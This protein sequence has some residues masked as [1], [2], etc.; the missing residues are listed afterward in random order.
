MVGVNIEDNVKGE[1]K[2][3]KDFLSTLLD[4]KVLEILR[5][6]HRKSPFYEDKPYSSPRVIF[7]LPVDIFDFVREKGKR[8]LTLVAFVHLHTND[9]YIPHPEMELCHAYGTNPDLY[10]DFK[11]ALV[12]G[13]I[14]KFA[15]V[16][17]TEKEEGDDDVSY[18]VYQPL[19]VSVS[20]EED[21]AEVEDLLNQMGDKEIIEQ[22]NVCIDPT[23][24][25]V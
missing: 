1:T 19:Y 9:S 12:D 3:E 22:D 21:I 24:G 18:N 25:R 10:G 14:P 23:W 17:L 4:K 13:S 16:Q 5:K 11:K 8:E 7:V 2:L 15:R 20:N 6:G